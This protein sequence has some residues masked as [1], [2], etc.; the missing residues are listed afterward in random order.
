MSS[1]I[2]PNELKKKI[3]A[4][5]YRKLTKTYRKVYNRL[6]MNNIRFTIG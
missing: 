3:Q 1:G 4:V 2:G 5:V 6:T